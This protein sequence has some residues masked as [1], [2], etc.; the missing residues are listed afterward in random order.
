MRHTISQTYLHNIKRDAWEVLSASR[1]IYVFH[2]LG[3]SLY[4]VWDRQLSKRDYDTPIGGFWT[5]LTIWNVD[6]LFFDFGVNSIFFRI[7]TAIDWTFPVTDNSW[8]K[9][10]QV[11]C[12]F[13][14]L[15]AV[16]PTTNHP[17][18]TG[19]FLKTHC[20]TATT[21]FDCRLLY[22]GLDHGP[23]IGMISKSM[24]VLTF[25]GNLDFVGFSIHLKRVWR[26]FP[27]GLQMLIAC[28]VCRFKMNQK[29]EVRD[30]YHVATVCHRAIPFQIYIIPIV[31]TKLA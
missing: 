29:L 7:G 6:C 10:L 1:R 12:L 4:W 14:S 2:T 11:F 18:T 26:H 19:I 27:K 30:L 3:C 20:A 8:T 25:F 21:A 31:G 24:M 9:T 16:P 15:L 5:S 22:W 17:S 28:S 13:C 23:L